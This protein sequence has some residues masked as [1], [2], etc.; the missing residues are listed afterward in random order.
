[1]H[2]TYCENAGVTDAARALVRSSDRPLA[3]LELPSG[4]FLAVNPAF[5]S[6]LGSTVDA[7]VGSSSVERLHPGE[8][9]AAQQCLQALA[10]GSLTGYQAVRRQASP[11]HPDE[12]FSI[13]VSVSDAGGTRVGLVSLAPYGGPG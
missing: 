2:G 3:V 11:G 7:L 12:Q 9:R 1:M 5:A 13:W 4:E 8:R 6:A 10:D